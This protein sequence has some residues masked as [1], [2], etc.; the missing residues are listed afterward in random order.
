MPKRKLSELNGSDDRKLS[1]KAVRLGVKFDHGVQM[2]SKGLKTARGFERQKLS[3][4]EKTAKSQDNSTAL[5]KLV[6]EVNALKALDYNVTAAKYLFKQLSKT[7]RI[8]EC[9]AFKEFEESR[10]VPTNGPKSTAEAN[11]LGRLFSSTPVKNVVPT[12]ISEIRKLL[13][14]DE[15]PAGK[16]DKAETKKDAGS[17][18]K[19]ARKKAEESESVSGSEDEAQPKRSSSTRDGERASH[20]MDISGDEESGSDEFADFDA[21]L[22][23]GSD[24]EGEVDSD[25]GLPMKSRAL[26]DD[27][28]D[29]V[30][31]SPSPAFSA[32]DSPPSKKTKAA[33]GSDAPVQST[34][35]LPSLMGGYWSGS[36][37][38]S[39]GEEEAAAP[40]RKNRMG[41]QARRALWEKKFGAGANHVQ[42]EVKKQKKSRDS[43]W[44][45]RKGATDGGRGGRFGGPGGFE[46]RGLSDRPHN[47]HNAGGQQSSSGPTQ[48]SR[49]KPPPSK[50]DEGPLH[51]SWEA[52]KKLKEQASTAKF[53]G[54]KVTFD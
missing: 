44:D 22:G 16:Q 38:A 10:N 21:R 48:R 34:T 53:Q 32:A 18:E 9:P 41:Q 19:S 15:A 1:M 37:D 35:F 36:E 46:D 3:R 50:D 54:T 49:L 5:S 8:A 31:R 17:K 39:D 47:V 14:V 12:I 20:D 23:P 42:K 51:P 6:E 33:R 43:G 11:I 29:S 2:I 25:G 40:K 52:K 7:K 27:I 28:S 4:R 30:S 45:T 13:E 26:A 24:S